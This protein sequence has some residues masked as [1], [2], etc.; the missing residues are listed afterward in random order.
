M[1]YYI[2]GGVLLVVLV[3][4]VVV[5]AVCIIKKRK[6]RTAWEQGLITQPRTMNQLILH[7]DARTALSN[8]LAVRGRHSARAELNPS[9][10]L[11]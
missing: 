5:I 1:V 11:T 6:K 7:T 3:I 2:V 9:I 8:Q 4:T 10:S